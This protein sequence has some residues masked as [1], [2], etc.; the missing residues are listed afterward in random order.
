MKKKLLALLE[1][2]A[3][4]FTITHRVCFVCKIL[5]CLEGKVKERQKGARLLL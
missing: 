5:C 2:S 3:F 1:I 4:I